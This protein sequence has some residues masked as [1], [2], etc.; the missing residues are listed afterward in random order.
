MTITSQDVD[1]QLALWE[2]ARSA[3]PIVTNDDPL[4]ADYATEVIAFFNVLS[5]KPWM[6]NDYDPDK[7]FSSSS[8]MAD[9]LHRPALMNCAPG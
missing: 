1:T 2:D 5:N 8:T 7:T 4:L 6:Q 3:D 9:L